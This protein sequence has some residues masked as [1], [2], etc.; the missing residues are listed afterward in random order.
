M[1]YLNEYFD[2]YT[3][4]GWELEGSYWVLYYD[5]TPVRRQHTNPFPDDEHDCNEWLAYE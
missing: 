5:G 2:E 4:D 1:S 3:G